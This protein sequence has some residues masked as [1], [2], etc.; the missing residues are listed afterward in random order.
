MRTQARACNAPGFFFLSFRLLFVI[1]FDWRTP[2]DRTRKMLPKNLAQAIAEFD[3][4]VTRVETG[5]VSLHWSKEER[6]TP[7]NGPR[8]LRTHRAPRG[9]KSDLRERLREQHA[10]V[11]ALKRKRLG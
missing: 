11:K 9:G 2:M 7:I 1:H 4:D 6:A 3:G 10:Q 5:A 8:N